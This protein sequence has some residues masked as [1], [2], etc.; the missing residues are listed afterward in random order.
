MIIVSPPHPPLT[1]SPTRGVHRTPALRA[2]S[3][4]RQ[5]RREESKAYLAQ[6][7]TG[8]PPYVPF[9]EEGI[10]E[11][12]KGVERAGIMGVHLIHRGAVDEVSYD[13]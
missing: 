2:P 4:G 12:G 13:E 1:R 8:L 11:E 3:R 5:G 10:C 7:V 9:Q 6:E